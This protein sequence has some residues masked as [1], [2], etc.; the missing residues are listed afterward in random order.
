MTHLNK[1]IIEDCFFNTLGT[2]SISQDK[3]E[4]FI[5]EAD[6]PFMP[7]RNEV[8]QRYFWQLMAKYKTPAQLKQL[9]Q[10]LGNTPDYIF[11]IKYKL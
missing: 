6:I 2:F 9:Q 10:R 8:T 4:D 7:I 5:N 3:I 11:Y 1:F